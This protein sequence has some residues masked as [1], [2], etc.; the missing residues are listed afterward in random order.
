MENE[1]TAEYAN[2]YMAGVDAERKR[3]LDLINE[4]LELR[5]KPAP[6]EVKH[7]TDYLVK[8][9]NLEG[10]RQEVLNSMAKELVADMLKRL[11]DK[12]GK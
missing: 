11:E 12:N 6:L 3:I 9:I 4:E 7:W 2:G 8:L 10:P 1:M 5:P